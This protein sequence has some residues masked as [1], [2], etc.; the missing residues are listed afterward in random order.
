MIGSLPIVRPNPTRFAATGVNE[1]SSSSEQAPASAG[2]SDAVQLSAGKLPTDATALAQGALETTQAAATQAVPGP[3]S[4]TLRV[5]SLNT[6]FDSRAGVDK[7]VDLIKTTKAD[8]VGV[9]E[10]NLNTEKLAE[11]LGMEYLQQGKRTAILSRF[12]IE[13]VSPKK[14]GVAVTLDNG[15][16]VGFLN[17]HTTSFPNHPHQLMHLAMGGGP[18][19]DTEREAIWWA[20]VTRGR[21]FRDMVKESDA[22]G[23]P[24]MITGDFNEP[25]HLDWTEEVV[26]TGRHPIT[27]DWPGSRTLEKAGFKDSYRVKNP[28]PLTHPGNTWTPTTSPDDP[29]DHHDRIDFVMYRGPELK[30][31]DSQV[32][33]ESE[34]F[35]DIVIDPYP[36][37][38]RAVLA[39]FEVSAP[40]P[41][42]GK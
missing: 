15:Q 31:V 20:N 39:T 4:T 18:Y 19:I 8:L 34:E 25:S 10:T 16:K 23:L 27:V 6:F 24:T 42:T 5:L 11:S 14:Y 1:S 38:H 22:L 17:A 2:V 40:E 7:M 12:P 32:V 13:E 28:D 33:G 41:T 21:E 29:E 35:A 9:Q 36:T 37:D 26:A 30:L 3:V